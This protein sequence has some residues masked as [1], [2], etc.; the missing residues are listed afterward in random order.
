LQPAPHTRWDAL[1]VVKLPML[2]EMLKVRRLGPSP[3]QAKWATAREAVANRTLTTAPVLLV[4]HDS[5]DVCDGWHRLYALAEA[6]A[7]ECAVAT[8][9]RCALAMGKAGLIPED[10]ERQP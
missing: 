5:I 9:W 10:N 7:T 3:N 6:G 8:T 1:V 4:A 2:M